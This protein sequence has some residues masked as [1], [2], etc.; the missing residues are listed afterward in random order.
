LRGIELLVRALKSSG[1]NFCVLAQARG[2]EDFSR[3]LSEQGIEFLSPISETAST[4]IADGYSRASGKPA[5]IITRGEVPK[6]ITGIGSAWADKTPIILISIIPDANE[7]FSPAFSRPTPD[8]KELFQPVTRFQARISRAEEIPEL[9]IR[10]YREAICFRG[11]PV[12]LELVESALMEDFSFGPEQLQPME[13]KLKGAAEPTRSS[14]DPDRIEKALEMLSSAKRPLIF[15]GGGVIR[16]R[17]SAELNQLAEQMQI[18]MISSMGGM[19]S[20]LPENPMYIGPPSYLSGEAFHHAIKQADVVLAVGCVFSGLDGFGLPPVWSNSIRFIQINIDP[21]HIGFNPKAELSILGD[22]QLILNQM[23]AQAKNYPVPRSRKSWIAKLQRLNQEHRQRI[24]DE[25]SRDWEKI[26]PASL[27][28]EMSKFLKEMPDFYVVLDGGNT[29]LW[30]GILVDLP[31]PGRGFFPTGMGTLGSG[32]PMAIGV[33]KAVGNARV[34]LVSGDGSF[35]YNLQELETLRKYQIPILV[36]IFNDSA[37]NMI[38]AGQV[39]FIGEVYGTDLPEADYG[40][41]AR[42][43]GCFGAKVKEKSGIEKAIRDALDSGLP[44]VIDV[45]IDPDS[46][47]DSLISFALVEFEGAPMGI[48]GTL[49]S[50]ISGKQKLDLRLW[51]QVKY[52]FKIS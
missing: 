23:L 13:S 9:L 20:A 29:C 41:A 19:G 10:A 31:G 38:R 46:I 47:P 51:N 16:A 18:P 30:A 34:I 11:G 52:I 5:I 40:K 22:A 4:M 28:L 1:V 45:E 2:L 27:V 32:I 39:S 7:K 8:F 33:K 50:I 12:F 17:A 26:H 36:I 25:A 43:F 15:S 21:E 37:W 42:S 35:L 3:A 48:T 44:A 49:K 14:A 6:L 24:I